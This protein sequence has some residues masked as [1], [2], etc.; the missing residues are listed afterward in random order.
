MKKK[1][2]AIIVFMLCI[3]FGGIGL[4]G[5]RFRGST[6]IQ[7][8][9]GY[10]VRE[11]Q[12]LYRQDDSEWADDYLGNSTYTMESSGC[13]VTCIAAAISAGGEVVKPGE[14]NQ[15]FS[16]KEVYD[17]EGNLQ[18]GVLEELENYSVRVYE[19]FAEENI[20]G[21]LEEGHFPI[22]R[23]RMNGIGSF[24]YVLIVGSE[25]GDYICM[26]PLEED[27]TTLSDYFDRVYAVRC[28]WK[29]K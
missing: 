17:E 14:L 15:M 1:S 3:I 8:E 13:L 23:V 19:R 12:I 5:V 25:E 27:L 4:I 20:V 11:E 7:P 24:H 18:W 9:R 10:L 6:K 29:E 2:I 16:E 22:V 28:V 26:D 21:C